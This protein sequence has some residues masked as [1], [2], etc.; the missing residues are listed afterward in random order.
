MWD[1]YQT[2]RWAKRLTLQHARFPRKCEHGRSGTQNTVARV[3]F[4]VAMARAPTYHPP[5]TAKSRRPAPPRSFPIVGIGA[6]AG[7]LEAFSELLRALPADT[8]MA[9][10]LIQ[11]LDPTH[12]SR[13]DEAL[14]RTT[15]MPVGEIV[16]GM[17]VEPD[18]VY[19]IPPNADLTLSNGKLS[20]LPPARE[21]RKPHLP[22][23]HF[24]RALAEACGHRAI[25]VVLSGTASDGTEGL[26]AIKAAG[27]V[28]LVQDPATARFDGMPRSAANA[29][30]V[31]L[32]LPL[33]ELAAELTRLGRHPYL[34]GREHDPFAGRRGEDDLPDLFARLRA[35]TGVD[36]GEYKTTTIKRRLA[37]RLALHR[38][39]TLHEYVRFLAEHP[40]EATALCEDLLIH[41]TSF[42]RDP[43]LFETLQRQVFPE[44]LGQKPEGA[45]LRVWVAG[46]STGQEVYSLAIALFEALAE[47]GSK[48]A[49]QIFGTDVSE[50]AIE[51]VRAGFYPEPVVLADVSPERVRRFFTKVEGGYR[52]AKEIRDACIFVR[53]DLA[54]DP[55]FS[56]LDLV[57]CRNVLIYLN[58]SL[59]R[60][61]LATFHYCLNQPGFLVLG[62]SENVSGQQR[63]FTAVDK[64]HKIFTRSS[65]AASL[66]IGG[67]EG[68]SNRRWV[69][70][71]VADPS[72]AIPDVGKQLDGL[73]LARYAPPGVVVNERADVLQF[74][75]HTGAYLEP[76]PGHAHFNLLKMAR[77]GL[78]TDLR[79]ALASAKR[80]KIA[81]RRNGV[82]IREKDSK[83]RVDLVV[84]PVGGPSGAE[85][86]FAVL[87]E[88]AT[89]AG[90]RAAPAGRPRGGESAK[91][92]RELAATKDY[93]QSLLEDHQTTNDELTSANEELVS[94]N[95]EL[96]SMN[97]EL[98]TAKEELQS[99]NE[100]LNTVND[101]LQNRNQQLGQVNNDLVNI[102]N[103]VE[104]PIV[105][106]DSQR[107]I[108][109]FTPGARTM[110]NLRPGDVGRPLA[111]VRPN[112]LIDDLD[113]QIEAVL[114]TL[115]TKELEAKDREGR[116]YRIQ[117]RPYKTIDNKIE[118]VVL[119]LVEIDALKRAVS[120]AEWHRDWA[121][122][123][124]EAVQVPL[125]VLDSRI[126][127]V[128]AN[129]AF[130]DT[131]GVSRSETESRSLY[132]LGLSQWNI[133]SL[134]QS[135]G[136]ML[137]SNSRFQNVQVERDFPSLGRRT[138]S[139]SARPIEAQGAPAMILLAIQDVTEK[140][141]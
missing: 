52:I 96:Q 130:Y 89:P 4:P 139:L 118:G 76:S 98:E 112:L 70:H 40:E 69:P 68:A 9:F 49:V 63:L 34:S 102:L 54:R 23:D 88:E 26:K 133:P 134:R 75:G 87:F 132:E 115:T 56:R 77:E 35:A 101:E 114:E 5:V 2:A 59:Q 82:R 16:D 14:G 46:C 95:E 78:L 72:R 44:L 18:H 126:N 103:S 138:M 119:S 57:S 109:R 105:I 100:E 113:E 45:P 7:G 13:L 39:A 66:Q 51:F 47:S 48:R 65:A 79:I 61:I 106:L 93:L 32:V 19:V 129:Q 28:T 64:A 1:S 111:E 31:D 104:I 17:K 73:L 67:G 80:Q 30:V 83:R 124:V 43:D 91:L 136:E 121:A 50:A 42:F 108:R 60:R 24:F 110:M 86:L 6:S 10:V 131:F 29:G 33:D 27:G 15:S 22:I 21:P 36:F 11:H 140:R 97:E 71:V 92:E 3:A 127:V 53:H 41:V 107:R 99:T 81:V 94:T 116:W 62:R 55:P 20:L 8:G 120:T 74:R 37:R 141:P 123:I 90:R 117:I 85:P 84:I 137:A 125:I 25:G 122:S 135:L 38:L 128:S 58:P 12:P